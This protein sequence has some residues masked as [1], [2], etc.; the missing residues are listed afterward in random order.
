LALF[1]NNEQ[2]SGI[3]MHIIHDL[4]SLTKENFVEDSLGLF[5]HTVAN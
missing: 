4:H 1:A 3:N 5:I 2:L